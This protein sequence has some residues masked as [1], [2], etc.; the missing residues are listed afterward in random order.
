M[1]E[2]TCD[3]EESAENDIS[4]MHTETH[5]HMRHAN[6]WWQE[7]RVMRSGMESSL[8]A[9]SGMQACICAM[10]SGWEMQPN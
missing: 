8:V 3:N 4:K 1:N 5:T 7:R 2:F 6:E 10:A 9:I